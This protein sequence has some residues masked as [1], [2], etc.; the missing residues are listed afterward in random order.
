MF[1]FSFFFHFKR[2]GFIR[3]F[4]WC[5][6]KAKCIV[7][8]CLSECV[9]VYLWGYVECLWTTW[10]SKRTKLCYW[11][12]LVSALPL[13]LQLREYHHYRHHLIQQEAKLV[14]DIPT[15][16]CQKSNKYFLHTCILPDAVCF[17]KETLSSFFFVWEL[18]KQSYCFRLIISELNGWGNEWMI[19]FL[20]TTLEIV[21]LT[22]V[23]PNFVD[24]G[25]LRFPLTQSC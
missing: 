11:N 5:R 19:E 7:P 16:Q 14:G 15:A 13:Q 6:W 18:S 20:C 3:K 1:S 2:T 25:C 12:L 23:S 17:N 22:A 4:P 10:L 24:L 8:V 9:S 21:H